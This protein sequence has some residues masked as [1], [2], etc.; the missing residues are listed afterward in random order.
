MPPFNEEDS[1]SAVGFKLIDLEV[2]KNIQSYNW[3]PSPDY[4]TSIYICIYI[5]TYMYIYICN[6]IY[7]YIY[8]TWLGN[9]G[10][11]KFAQ[12][13]TTSFFHRMS[14]KAP[15]HW[16]SSQRTSAQ[17]WGSHSCWRLRRT[18]TLL[19][20][21]TLDGSNPWSSDVLDDASQNIN[22]SLF[23]QCC[24]LSTSVGFAV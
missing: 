13:T 18:H 12:G 4:P 16:D 11:P 22:M 10:G 6:Y 8:S 7:T 20:L 19:V 23:H 3:Q 21:M 17:A 1:L 24:R 15:I 14:I 9:F 2:M 5:Y